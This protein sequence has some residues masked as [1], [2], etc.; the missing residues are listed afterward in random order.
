MTLTAEQLF[1]QVGKQ[2]EDVYCDNPGLKKF[3]NTSLDMLQPGSAVLDVGCGTGKPVADQL[4]RAGHEVYG[5]DVSQKMIEVAQNQVEGRFVKADMTSFEPETKFD[6]VYTVFSLFQLTNNE[7][8]KMIFR[9]SEWLQPGGL[10]VFG[11]VPSTS[12]VKDPKDYDASGKV[13]RHYESEFMQQRVIYTLYTREKWLELIRSAGFEI[14]LKQSCT[15]QVDSRNEIYDQ[16]LVIAKKQVT[17]ALTGP[18]PLP[19]SYRGPH[20]LCEAAWAPFIQ[21]LVRDEIEAVM[22][23]LQDNNRV[24]DIGSG[25]GSNSALAL[26]NVSQPL[27]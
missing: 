10:L 20:P 18:F 2:Y 7:I 19:A 14:Q 24:L 9:F 6:A 22:E 1:N 23:I 25:H 26:Y 3:I 16:Y 21:R 4:A 17:H 15:L 11:M 8:Y 27:N 5:I 13:A 12:F